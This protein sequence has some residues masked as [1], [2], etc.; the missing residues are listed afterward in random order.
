MFNG[1]QHMELNARKLQKNKG[2]LVCLVFVLDN[3]KR[4]CSDK[5]ELQLEKPYKSEKQQQNYKSKLDINKHQVLQHECF[6]YL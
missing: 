1:L 6:S 3:G 5:N 2:A 4:N